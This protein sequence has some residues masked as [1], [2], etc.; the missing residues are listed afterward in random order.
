[1]DDVAL[2]ATRAAFDVSN[3]LAGWATIIVALG[4]FIEF[5]VLFIFAKEMDRREKVAVA[6][7]TALIVI[8]VIGEWWFGGQAAMASEALQR[9][10]A[11][12]AA[13][14]I[15]DAA[16]ASERAGKFEAAAAAAGNAAAM[17]QKDAAGANERA[18]NLEREAAAANERAAE[19]MKATAWRQ[20]SQRQKEQLILAFS[21]HTGKVVIAWIAN[22]AE[23]FAL[24][25]Q[26]QAILD[27]LPNKD[28]WD[29][30][31]SV[32]TYPTAVV[33]DIAIPE[34]AYCVVPG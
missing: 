23:S 11:T 10:A 20:F 30:T 4:V 19:I 31:F 34:G 2:E 5:I 25:T 21:Q 7:A 32:K 27:A 3:A 9:D 29:V 6:F 17:A 15:R 1:M 33:W 26:F 22:D 13:N 18:A 28:Q 16:Q 12:K 14:A 8:G 24:A